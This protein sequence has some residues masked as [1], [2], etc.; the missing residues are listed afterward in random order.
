MRSK[1]NKIKLNY[2][3]FDKYF[4][5]KVYPIFLD[6]MVS[7][8]QEVELQE[9]GKRDANVN[10][11]FN[12]CFYMAQYL[13]RNNPKY[14]KLGESSTRYDDSGIWEREQR[15]RVLKKLKAEIFASIERHMKG[16]DWDIS[17]VYKIWMKIDK[18]L[19]QKGDL[20]QASVIIHGESI[21]LHR[22]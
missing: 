17:E 19:D 13:M 20:K 7:L 22:L 5:T 16:K 14:P 4:L 3:E 18:L 9:T 6:S 15:R 21:D 12:P 8:A 1:K 11:R 2:L 10:D